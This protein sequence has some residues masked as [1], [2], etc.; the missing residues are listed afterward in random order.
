MH[1]NDVKAS[2]QIII[3]CNFLINVIRALQRAALD[4]KKTP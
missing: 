4:E 1:M 2:N 3:Y